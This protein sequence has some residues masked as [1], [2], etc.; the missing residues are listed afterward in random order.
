MAVIYVGPTSAGSANGT[1]WANRYG[2][3]SAAEAKP[4][5]AGDLVY[6]GPGVYREL[7]TVGVSGSSGL[8]ITYIAD[9]DGSHTDGIGGVVRVTGSN[10]DQVATR[11]NCIT[12]TS[13]DFRTFRGFTFDM[14]TNVVLI[15]NTA[16]NNWIIE[17]CYFPAPSA[18]VN[19][20]T[21]SGNNT[22]ITIRRC[23]FVGSRSNMI[24]FTTAATFN[25]AGHLIENCLFIGGTAGAIQTTRIG[26]ITVKNC[27][28]IAVIGVGVRVA[29]A[30]AVG[31]TITVNNCIF[32]A[33]G[34]A[35][36]ATVTTE[37]TEN[38][39]SFWGNNVDRTTVSVGA[40]S[41]AFPPLF[42]Q[43]I[44]LDGFLMPWNAFALSQWSPLRRLTGTAMSSEDFFGIPR[45]ATASKVS[46]GAVQ[47]ND[48][49]RETTTVRTGA[50]S[51][52][53]ADAGVHQMFVPTT[54]VS[55]VFS[56]YVQWEA[57]YAGTK[58]QMIIHQPG[59]SDTTVTATGSSGAWELL[60]TTLTPAA[61]PGYC[62]VELRSNN[63]AATTSI[64]TY[65]DDFT[66]A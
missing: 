57:N 36:Q 39:N 53:I 19:T 2:S 64:A 33:C 3:L 37:F 44:L 6:C 7:L 42:A 18:S 51:I 62:V 26:G 45:P 49:N 24:S 30:L 52:K 1:S 66:A 50:A 48:L 40:N 35:L 27:T 32:F 4:V 31:Q 14:T 25:N 13:K 47:F 61:S 46:W 16:A 65:F 43:P 15:H 56:V 5:A 34:T 38:F 11:A 29:V 17:D 59:Q 22:N 58:P 23:V 28:F 10:D 21:S 8:P 41:N 9:V 20:I 54:N 63:S 12:A 60:T 55:T